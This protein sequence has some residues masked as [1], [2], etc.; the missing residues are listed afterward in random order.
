MKTILLGVGVIFSAT[1]WA[2]MLIGSLLLLP[3]YLWAGSIIIDLGGTP[4]TINTS[5][6]QGAAIQRTTDE[7]NTRATAK[8]PGWVDIS[9]EKWLKRVLVSA[10]NDYVK[11]VRKRDAAI[12]CTAI[13]ADPMLE[14]EVRDL[15]GG[16]IPCQ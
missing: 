13:D 9:S 14:Q 4:E 1:L 15:L 10:V 7:F 3:T 2:V 5:S 11:Q 6:K 8:D 12:A 16:R